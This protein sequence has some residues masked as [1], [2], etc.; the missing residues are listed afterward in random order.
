ME[1]M[2]QKKFTK[3]ADFIRTIR[4]TI[5]SLEKLGENIQLTEYV[6]Y[7]TRHRGA[8]KTVLLHN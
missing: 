4:P 8:Q 5:T 3:P 1:L 7:M 2:A 6:K